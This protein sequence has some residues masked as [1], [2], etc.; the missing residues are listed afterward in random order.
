MSQ[1]DANVSVGTTVY[2]EKGIPLGTVRGFDEDGFFV[3]TREDITAMSIG[4]ERAGHEFGEAELVWRCAD[5]GETGE[6]DDLPDR[7]PNC[8]APKEALFYWI[9]D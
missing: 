4:H 8:N 5:C 9:E 1:K 2:S 7:C 6:L 3:T